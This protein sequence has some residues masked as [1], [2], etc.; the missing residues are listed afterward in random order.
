M[1]FMMNV[2]D[3]IILNY[4]KHLQIV[5][6]VYQFVQLLMKKLFVCMEDYLLN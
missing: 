4:G 3:D 5:L 6:I 2:K 1:D